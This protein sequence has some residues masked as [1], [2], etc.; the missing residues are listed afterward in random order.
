MNR[1]MPG[2][3]KHYEDQKAGQGREHRCYFTCMIM[4]GPSGK[5]TSEQRLEGSEG[6]S[7]E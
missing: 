3:N 4:E 2:G 1:Y 5:V 6:Q 7:H